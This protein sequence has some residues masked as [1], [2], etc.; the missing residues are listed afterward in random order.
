M[1]HRSNW[2]DE[3]KQNDLFKGESESAKHLNSWKSWKSPECQQTDQNQH[4]S[5]SAGLTNVAT[6]AKDRYNQIY[7]CHMDQHGALAGNRSRSANKEQFDL[8]RSL[9]ISAAQH[10]KMAGKNQSSWCKAMGNRINRETS[11]LTAPVQQIHLPLLLEVLFC[12]L[13]PW[14]PHG[15]NNDATDLQYI[16]RTLC[17]W[18]TVDQYVPSVSVSRADS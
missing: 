12:I 13:E 15:S 10:L 9:R 6:S 1:Q 3:D 4:G 8:R 11:R 14:R 5:T 18:I 16:A 17:T 7:V 2:D